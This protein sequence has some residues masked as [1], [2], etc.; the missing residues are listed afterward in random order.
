MRFDT[1]A[2]ACLNQCGEWWSRGDQI[3]WLLLAWV[4]IVAFCVWNRVDFS[5]CVLCREREGGRGVEIHMVES[6]RAYKLQ[7]WRFSHERMRELLWLRLEKER[8]DMR[9]ERQ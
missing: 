3:G 1:V 4:S 5:C 2:G 9:E 8:N 6:S 7:P